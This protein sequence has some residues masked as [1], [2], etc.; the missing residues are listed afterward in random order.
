MSFKVFLGQLGLAGTALAAVVVTSQAMRPVYVGRAPLAK[1]LAAAEWRDSTAERAPWAVASADSALRT[2]Q[3]EEDRRNFAAD[4]RRTGNMSAARADSLATFAVREAYRKRV[5]PAL[6]FGVM[7]VENR[8]FKSRARSNVGAVGLMQVY[9]KVWVPTLGK[10]FGR[11]L[12][13]DEVN[14]RYGVHILSHYVHSAL[15]AEGAD[16]DRVMRRGLLR[17]NGCVRGTNTRGCHSYPDKVRAMVEQHALAQCG[18]ADYE[19]C[20][21]EPLLRSLATGNA[22]LAMRGVP[23]PVTTTGGLVTSTATGEVR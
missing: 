9:G 14:L 19:T 10:R 2:P 11:D 16:A 22:V 5:P 20:V 21:G 1:R 7:L 8:S 15:N 4:L 13:N 6:V 17:Y 18:G 23:A 3:F 12:R